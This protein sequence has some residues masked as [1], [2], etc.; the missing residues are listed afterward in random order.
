[1]WLAASG[2]GNILSTLA[3]VKTG[4]LPLCTTIPGY[5]KEK[6]NHQTQVSC[7]PG[8][9]PDDQSSAIALPF[10]WPSVHKLCVFKK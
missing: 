4:I 7:T 5:E 8:K 2:E 1:M 3:L 6:K 10:Q 9:L